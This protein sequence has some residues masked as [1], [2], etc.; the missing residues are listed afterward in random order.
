VQ[1][2]KS[3]VCVIGW[4]DE[5]L[6]CMRRGMYSPVLSPLLALEGENSFVLGWEKG[7]HDACFLFVLLSVA[8]HHATLCRL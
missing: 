3:S 8:I 4:G 5:N 6:T 7:I 1:E 2:D